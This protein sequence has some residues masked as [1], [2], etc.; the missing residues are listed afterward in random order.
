[1]TLFPC[2]WL[3]RWWRPLP[4]SCE[5]G[6]PADHVCQASLFWVRLSHHCPASSVGRVHA[7]HWAVKARGAE[8]L[9]AVTGSSS[10]LSVSYSCP[11]FGFYLFSLDEGTFA[12]RA[13]R[14]Q[15]ERAQGRLN[16]TAAMNTCVQVS[17]FGSLRYICRSGFA[18]SYGMVLFT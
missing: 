13:S 14:K 17:A 8:D 16:S 6:E 7:S 10:H 9:G 12:H 2:L 11:H 4:A 3:P 15:V 1:M 5:F 18:G